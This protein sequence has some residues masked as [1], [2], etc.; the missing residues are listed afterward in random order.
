MGCRFGRGG[1]KGIVVPYLIY[2]SGLREE[3]L[4]PLPGVQRYLTCNF[5]ELL[6]LGGVGVA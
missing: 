2:S 6:I 5:A 1:D 4:V 3:C